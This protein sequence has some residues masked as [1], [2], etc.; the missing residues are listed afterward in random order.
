MNELDLFGNVIAIAEP[1][2]RAEFLDRECAGRPDLRQRLDQLLVAHARAHPLL[3]PPNAA[4]PSDTG[5]QAPASSLVGAVIAGRY[6][7]LEEIG[8]GGMGAVW[9][10]EQ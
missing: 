10:A 7:L 4:D 5:T 9:M 6:K 8:E 1:S 2:K 3:D